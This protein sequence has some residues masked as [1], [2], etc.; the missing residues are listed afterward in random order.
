[1]EIKDHRVYVNGTELEEPY[2]SEKPLGDFPKWW[3]PRIP[4]LYWV[5]IEMTAGTAGMPT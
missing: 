4:C 2:I 3:F 1:M 5:I